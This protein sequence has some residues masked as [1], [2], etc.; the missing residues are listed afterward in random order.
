MKVSELTGSA[1]DW[2]VD[3]RPRR[4][5]ILRAKKKL[6]RDLESYHKLSHL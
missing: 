3:I 1:L 6:D 2:A 4:K 5:T